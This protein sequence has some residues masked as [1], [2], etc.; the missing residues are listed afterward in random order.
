MQPRLQPTSSGAP[1]LRYGDHFLEDPRDPIGGAATFA[2]SAPLDGAA[3]VVLFGHGL[4][5]RPAQLRALGVEPLILEPCA[6]I[7]A[8][9]EAATPGRGGPPMP[10]IHASPAA[11]VEAALRLPPRSGRLIL[12]A[13]P[14]YVRAFPEAHRGLLASLEELAG[15][16]ALRENTASSR[17]ALAIDNALTNLTN[18]AEIPDV[19]AFG[20][21]LRGKPAFLVSGG[22]SLDR[23]AHLLGQAA[24]RGAIVTMNTA[25]PALASRGVPI[26]ALL[27]MESLDVSATVSAL[28]DRP[29][30]LVLDLV[31]HPALHRRGGPRRAGFIGAG[32]E[33]AAIRE[34]LQIVGLP[35]GPSVATAAFS[36]AYR[37]GADPIVL[38]G[39]DL[40]FTGGKLYAQGT[41]REGMRA[42]ARGDRLEFGYDDSFRAIFERAGLAAPAPEQPRLELPGWGGGVV[43]S[44]HDLALNLRWFEAVAGQ[45][46]GRRLFDASEGGARKRGFVE[47]PLAALL[48]MLPLRPDARLSLG[49]AATPRRARIDRLRRSILAEMRAIERLA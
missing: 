37:W 4:G 47:R 36:L 46:R 20:T 25:A 5:H 49:S 45:A 6:A 24:R 9:C 48:E 38:V 18:L 26:D 27:V 22:P 33:L 31:A 43:S 23:N 8:L 17:R 1:T 16:L 14:A 7:L 15:F 29:G 13:P 44:N 30:L 42:R 34:A 21:P 28:G 3:I 2:S 39:Q 40:A 10:R 41:G 11:L 35:C 12:L 32:E 19:H